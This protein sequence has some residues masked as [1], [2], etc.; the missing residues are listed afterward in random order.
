M[1]PSCTSTLFF[2]QGDTVLSPN[3]EFCETNTERFVAIVALTPSLEPV[4]ELFPQT[5]NVFNVHLLGEARQS[6]IVSV[7]MELF[8]ILDVQRMHLQQKMS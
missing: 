2:N 6:I 4:F 8:E 5:S 7:Q 1:R 3:M